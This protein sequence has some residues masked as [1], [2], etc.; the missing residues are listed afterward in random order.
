MLPTDASTHSQALADVRS[1]GA[2]IKC[3]YCTLDIEYAHDVINSMNGTLLFSEKPAISVCF[4]KS[5]CEITILC[6][7]GL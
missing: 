4:G 5:G 6:N 3:L 2:E 7:T 1:T